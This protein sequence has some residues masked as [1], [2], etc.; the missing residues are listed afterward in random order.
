MRSRIPYSRLITN[1]LHLRPHLRIIGRGHGLGLDCKPYWQ[2]SC[3]EIKFHH[4]PLRSRLID[5]MDKPVGEADL[6]SMLSENTQA[7]ET[8]N[9]A[10]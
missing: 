4:E 3:S 7:A 6:E 8:A 2:L 1:L 5:T 10:K 9:A